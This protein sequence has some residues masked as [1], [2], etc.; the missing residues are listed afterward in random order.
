MT[1]HELIRNDL[2]VPPPTH[3]THQLIHI[4]IYTIYNHARFITSSTI[5][6]LEA[7]AFAI[8]KVRSY[9]YTHSRCWYD[10]LNEVKD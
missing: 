4:Y 2:F 6:R 3:Y 5:K 1:R 10:Y 9:R 7:M 8:F